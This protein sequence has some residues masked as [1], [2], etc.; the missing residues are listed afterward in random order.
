MKN[1]LW[2][3]KKN[4]SS[5]RHR[6]WRS[7]K[8]GSDLSPTKQYFAGEGA[9]KRGEKEYKAADVTNESNNFANSLGLTTNEIYDYIADIPPNN[10]VVWFFW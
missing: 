10:K 8:K 5:L 2:Q 1:R 4:D 7:T 3:W 9:E 6:Y